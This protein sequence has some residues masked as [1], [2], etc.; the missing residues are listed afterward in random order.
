MRGFDWNSKDRKCNIF[1]GAEPWNSCLVAEI[2]FITALK[3]FS[4]EGDDLEV[5]KSV[6][7]WDLFFCTIGLSSG[8]W[9]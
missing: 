6:A 7:R 1:P 4:S 3:A 5:V 2:A 8:V 9:L